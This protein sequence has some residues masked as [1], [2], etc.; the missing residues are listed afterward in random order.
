MEVASPKCSSVASSPF[1]SPNVS[2]LL[3]IKIISWSQETGLPVSVCV[4][5]GN[6]A[7]NLHKCPLFSKSGYFK[8]RLKES[9]ELELPQD[10]PGGPETFEMIALFMYGSSTLIDPF[11]VVALRC[12]AEF[13]EMTEDHCIG[14]LCERFDLYLNQVVLQSWDDTLIVLQ[15]CQKLLPW[16]EELLIVSRCIESLAF[17]ACM[18]ILDPERRRDQPVITVEALA[19]QT[20][21]SGT[22]KE[23]AIQDLWIKDLIAL[24]FQFFKRIIG[25]LRRQGMKEKYVSPIIVF[26]AS[27]WVLSKKTRQFWENSG[28]KNKDKDKDNDINNKVSIILQGVL[29]LLPMGEKASRV[30]PVG[31]YFALLSRSLEVGLRSDNKV[32]LQ[33]QIVPLLHL[34]Q[35]EDLLLPR[36]GTDSISSSIE[37]ATMERIFSNYVSANMDAK[38]TPSVNNCIVAELWDVYLSLVAPDPNMGPKRFMYL[39]EI[40]LVSSRQTHDHLYRAMNAFLHAH[41]NISQEEKGM[42][43]KYLD[44]QK[45]SQEVCIEAV[46]N[47]LMPLRLI[48]QALFLQQMNTHQAFKECSDSFRYAHCGEFSGSLSSSRYPNSKSQNLGESPYMDGE[49]GSRPLS[50]LLQK[51]PVMQRSE[52]SKK[53]YES[54]SFRIQ[55]LEQELMSLKRNLQWQSMSKKTEQLSNKSQSLKSY[56]LDGKTLSKKRNTLGQATGCIGAVN[57]ASQR[58]Y[59]SRLLKVFRRI[60]LFGRGKSKRK[61]GAPGLWPKSM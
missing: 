50:F 38:H 54:T 37:L 46:Q 5:V 34:A 44:C 1:S 18:E 11:N 12:A 30:I 2:A 53:D 41:P 58:K 61:P 17:M 14:N 31:F 43:C 16:S 9:S 59:A 25:S 6:R 42:V 55:N 48:V 4:R 52:L 22:V 45:L 15:K 57:F 13:L 33:D 23:I 19:N 35:V 27:K 20:W 29:D 28:G 21:S 49:P 60:T 51:D 7:F 32:K 36:C 40:V 56:G 39:I 8:K 3:K 24:P 10:F 26:Y 47:E